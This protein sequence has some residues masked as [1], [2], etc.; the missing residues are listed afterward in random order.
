LAE[1]PEG[2]RSAIATGGR[3]ALP[4]KKLTITVVD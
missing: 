3:V 2:T 1:T 4:E